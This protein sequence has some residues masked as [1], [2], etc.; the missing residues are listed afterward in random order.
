MVCVSVGVPGTKGPVGTVQPAG[1]TR[2]SKRGGCGGKS[3]PVT[4]CPM[5]STE[6][7]TADP[8][9]TGGM[10]R[11]AESEKQK[12]DPAREKV[13][14][15]VST[16]VSP[17]RKTPEKLALTMA[18]PPGGIV[19]RESGS[20]GEVSVPPVKEIAVTSTFWIAAVPLLTMGTATKRRVGLGTLTPG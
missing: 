8:G 6:P 18:E 16:G 14:S 17:G 20:M 13:P 11:V 2:S 5:T 1:L 9:A 4:A 10:T 3:P 15:T 12:I 19:P 7:S